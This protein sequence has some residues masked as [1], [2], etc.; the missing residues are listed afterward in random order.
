MNE[1]A[2]LSLKTTQREYNSLPDDVDKSFARLVSREAYTDAIHEALDV[3]R[4]HGAA[5]YLGVLLLHQ[6]FSV[7]PG[8]LFQERRHTLLPSSVTR[9]RR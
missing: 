6:H 7:S 2:G 9:P 4:R 3:I 5:G 8:T 1:P